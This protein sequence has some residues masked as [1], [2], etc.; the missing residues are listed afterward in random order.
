[1][2]ILT[3]LLERD[4]IGI[5]LGSANMRVWVKGRGLVMDEPSAE[6]SFRSG[7]IPDFDTAKKALRYCLAKVD[8]GSLRRPRVLLSVHSDIIEEQKKTLEKAAQAVDAVL[9]LPKY[10]KGAQEPL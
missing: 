6:H 5:D 3:K 7:V 4:D 2:D 1:M 9:N 10:H 8:G